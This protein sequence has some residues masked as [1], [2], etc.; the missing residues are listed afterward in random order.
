MGC[1]A[2][3]MW[4]AT[5]LKQS[6]EDEGL[7]KI[8]QLNLI[9]AFSQ[10]PG[11]LLGAWAS[12]I[13]GRKLQQLIGFGVMTLIF[14]VLSFVPD[15]K[16]DMNVFI[17]VYALMFFVA[18]AGPNTTTYIMAAEAFPTC[19]RTTGHGLCAAIGKSG[20]LLG[21]A[22]FTTIDDQ[23]GTTAVFIVCAALSLAA[24]IVTQILVDETA[25]RD[26]DNLDQEFEESLQASKDADEKRSHI[27][28]E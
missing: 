27:E 22:T 16:D 20:A 28:I 19:F 10:V 18:N 23:G 14:G 12:D 26:L 5:I 17:P 1:A 6:N 2:H 8:A 24:L 13:I 25:W 4:T 11:Y 15:I 9:M 7:A 21:V 3:R